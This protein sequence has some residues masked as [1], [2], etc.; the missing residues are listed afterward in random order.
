MAFGVHAAICASQQQ[1]NATGNAGTARA[2]QS[3]WGKGGGC[4]EDFP[5]FEKGEVREQAAGYGGLKEAYGGLADVCFLHHT[6]VYSPLPPSL[7]LSRSRI[8][9]S[10]QGLLLL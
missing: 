3:A 2:L 10:L 7:P 6:A 9:A 1:F 8:L 5:R 4:R